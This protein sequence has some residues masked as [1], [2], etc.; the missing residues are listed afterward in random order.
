MISLY[1]VCETSLPIVTGL[2]ST[3]SLE[4]I[5]SLENKINFHDYNFYGKPLIVSMEG[6]VKTQYII[7][8]SELTALGFAAGNITSLGLDLTTAGSTLS[9]FTLNV[10]HTSLTA[11]TSTI[12]TVSNTVYSGSFVPSVGIN[13]ITFSTPFAWNGTSN[14]ILSFCWSNN[15]AVYVGLQKTL[16]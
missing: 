6:G 16:N 4:F 8:A 10:E 14:I 9:G 11:L 3:L 7:R 5:T 15:K 1:S 12:E 2:I 13:T